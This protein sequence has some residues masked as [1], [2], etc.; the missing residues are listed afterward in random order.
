MDRIEGFPMDGRCWWVRWVDHIELPSGGTAS[1]GVHVL[2][3]PLPDQAGRN[4]FPS[5]SDEGRRQSAP[6]K[7]RV[8]AGAIPGLTIGTVFR[9]G[10]RAG[11]LE[12]KTISVAFASDRCQTFIWPACPNGKPPLPDNWPDGWPYYLLSLFHYRLGPFRSS[13][14]LVLRDEEK[15]VI[16]PC[17][18]IFRALYAPH[19][20]IALALLTGPWDLTWQ[21]VANP[22]HTRP[23]DNGDW[24]IGLRRRIRNDHAPILANLV[25]SPTGK[26]AAKSIHT[27]LL[28]AAQRSETGD[29]RMIGLRADIPFDWDQLRMTVRCIR[30]PGSRLPKYFGFEITRIS[31]PRPPQS[32]AVLWYY[33]DNSGT[34]ADEPTP[35]DQ[36]PPFV[37]AGQALSVGQD[38]IV[39]VTSWDDPTG[40]N[41]QS[42]IFSVTGPIL[43]GRPP[44]REVPKEESF[45]YQGAI[46]GGEVEPASTTS[47]GNSGGSDPGVARSE[48]TA[49][50]RRVPSHRFVELI[51][52]LQRMHREGLI[53]AWRVVH[54]P[55]VGAEF[56]GGLVAWPFL[57][58]PDRKRSWCYIDRES[59]DI[60]SALVC[61]I[62]LAGVDVHW[63][64]VE[65]RGGTEAFRA[66]MFQAGEG[67]RK[68]VVLE[69]IHLAEQHRG[70]WPKSTAVQAF[71][72]GATALRTWKHQFEG[73][74]GQPRQLRPQPAL[75]ALRCVASV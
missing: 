70:I 46:R 32:P 37:S 50:P 55:F 51:E 34:P 59:E 66:V 68:S 13:N 52:L 18:E 16:I 25:L 45:T 36:P 42:E 29:E 61:E 60:R 39:D 1:P 15:S 44:Q 19:Q 64:E 28:A 35:T 53:D 22:V 74:D 17:F 47:A 71:E 11:K 20:E 73:E 33:R 58:R 40:S 54:P 23:R 49:T 9:D 12:A 72:A 2:L 65:T 21:Q 38:G 5:I 48:Y 7:C 67:E 56:E 41:P 30:L 4:S 31:W 57:N 63:L 75:A 3:S 27:A 26:R 6:Q 14:C 10:V 8:L 69:L 24:Q 43:E 62:R